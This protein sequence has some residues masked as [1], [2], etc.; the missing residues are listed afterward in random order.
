MNGSQYNDLQNSDFTFQTNHDGGI[1]AGISNGQPIVMR[2]AFKPI[3]S[4][5]MMQKTIDYQGN[6]V[7]Y[8]A[9]DRNDSCVVPRVFPVVEAMAAL[10]IADSILMQNARRFHS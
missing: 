8:C 4:V 3:P 1:Q 7:D 10:V 2:L 9:N 5:Q 6:S